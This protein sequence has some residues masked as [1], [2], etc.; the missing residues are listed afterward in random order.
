MIDIDETWSKWIGSIRAEEIGS[1]NL[2]IQAHRKS[3]APDTLNSENKELQ[4]I[5][6]Q[7]FMGP[8]LSQNF[9][10]FC[11]PIF[12]TGAIIN[13][14]PSIQELGSLPQPVHEPAYIGRDLCELDIDLAL[15]LGKRLH[16]MR[17][18]PVWRINRILHLYG[19]ARS[20]RDPLERFHQ[21]VRTLEGPTKPPNNGG[22]ARNFSERM[23]LFVGEGHRELF[24]RLYEQ[25]GAVEHL[26]EHEILQG[27]TREARLQLAKDAYIAEYTCRSII[28]HIIENEHLW[29]HFGT[30]ESVD[31]FWRL[32]PQERRRLWGDPIDPMQGIEG[33]DESMFSNSDLGLPS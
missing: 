27:K 16:V 13:Q 32:E 15:R 11:A 30:A 1:S 2:Y 8:L 31:S 21:Y 19:T 14:T 23:M 3:A 7:C 18:N 24:K 20:E 4:R 29:S 22:T 12:M 17:T 28:A 5:C 26:R 25:R 10:T 33:F 9:R 6:R